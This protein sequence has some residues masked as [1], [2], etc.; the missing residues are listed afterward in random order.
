M[1]AEVILWMLIGYF[2]LILFIARLTIKGAALNLNTFFTANRSSKWYV[3]TFG[4]VGVSISGITLISVPGEVGT[5]GMTYLQMVFGYVV[6]Y[7]IIAGILLPLYYK[8]QL[9]SI[10]SYLEERFGPRVYLGGASFFLLSRFL[11]TVIRFYLMLKVLDYLCFKHLGIPFWVSTAITVFFIYFYTSKGGL[12]TIIYTDLLQTLFILMA[13]CT[14]SITVCWSLYSAGHIGEVWASPYTR[15]FEW[16]WKSPQNFFKYFLSGVFITITM[17]G[18][19]QDLMQK[20]LSCKTLQESQKNMRM[21]SL[22]ILIVNVLFVGLGALLYLFVNQNGLPLPAHS[23]FLI[24]DLIQKHFGGWVFFLF[25]LGVISATYS[26]S[27]SALTALTTSF[28]VDVLRI[29]DFD[30]S[31]NLQKKNR[32]HLWLSVLFGISIMVVHYL[33]TWTGGSAAVISIVLTV[34][35]FS[36]GPLLGLYTF[37]IFT[38]LKVYDKKALWAIILAPLISLL[39][40]FN[41]EAWFGFKMGFEILLINGLLTFI[42][43]YFTRKSFNSTNN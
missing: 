41:S 13:V 36:Y 18:L 23:D 29:R 30:N 10:Y 12:Q 28:C 11:G 39:I 8:L 24:P 16:D 3:V 21:F 26:T 2:G 33:Q 17:T 9:P 25:L 34:A 20:N 31:Q 32:V 4:M 42:G 38:P 40:Y 1:S 19:D 27:D 15:V 22:V 6:G 43:L 5:K 37:G 14:V 35:G 7:W